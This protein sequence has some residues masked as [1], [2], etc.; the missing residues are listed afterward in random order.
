MF[1]TFLT[2]QYGKYVAVVVIVLIIVAGAFGYVK[3]KE[4]EAAQA[5]LV[6]FNQQQLE[7]TIKQNNDYQKKIEELSRIATDLL[8][9]NNELN[10]VVDLN[11]NQTIEFIDKSKPSV[12]LDPLFNQ[13]L[14]KIKGVK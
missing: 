4:H 2:S 10:S 11:A 7:L 14:K 6:N 3:L 8:A 1:L 5:A 9:K 12:K 13:T